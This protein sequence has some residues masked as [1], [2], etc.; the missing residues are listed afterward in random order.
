MSIKTWAN[1]TAIA[2]I[3]TLAAPVLHAASETDRGLAGHFAACLGRYAAEENYNQ[4]MGR[5]VGAAPE[6]MAVFDEL[7]A[8]VT[9]A[10]ADRATKRALIRT[11]SGAEGAHWSL[12]HSADFSINDRIARHAK[13]TAARNLALCEMLVLG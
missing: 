3:I 8:S 5:D 2:T 10:D 11:R 1:A 9:P 6:R 7:L 13:A 12:L 4:L